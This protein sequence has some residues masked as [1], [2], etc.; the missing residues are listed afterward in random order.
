MAALRLLGVCIEKHHTL[1]EAA[2]GK[3]VIYLFTELVDQKEQVN[4][5][6]ASIL[7]SAFDHIYNNL[8]HAND[9]Q[10]V[11]ESTLQI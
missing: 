8:S 3:L 9:K 5:L 10:V 6:A 7:Q 1:M 4:T 2:F 11:P